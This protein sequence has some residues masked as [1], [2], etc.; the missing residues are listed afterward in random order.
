[1]TQT[2]FAA[3]SDVS[4]DYKYYNAINWLENKGVVQGYSDGTFKPDQ[5]VK[6]GEFLKMLYE[7]VGMENSGGLASVLPFPDVSEDDWFYSYVAEGYNKNVVVGYEDGT[8]K[9]GNTIINVEAIKVVMA[10]YFDVDSLY[11]DG[12]SYSPCYGELHAV[13]APDPGD[14]WYN[15]YLY[16]ADN[17]CIIPAEMV[18]DEDLG[19]HFFL[20]EH[21]ITR[22]EMAE[23]LYRAQAVA[24]NSDGGLSAIYTDGLQ[25]EKY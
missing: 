20:A 6:R 21:E 25:P 1:M 5:S 7:T 16:V 3:F 4:T 2:A 8:F 15:K 22:G 18:Y 12:G 9:P 10:D 13:L 11:G 17:A 14:A 23:L 19:F 24:D